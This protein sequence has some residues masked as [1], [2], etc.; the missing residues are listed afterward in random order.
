[1]LGG[2]A[3]C[4]CNANMSGFRFLSGNVM[5]IIS[6]I[7]SIDS[8]AYSSWTA[9]RGQSV[10]LTYSF[11]TRLPSDATSDDTNGFKPMTTAQQQGVR[12]ALDSWAAVANISFTEIATGGNIQLGTNDQGDQSSGYAYLP[13]GGDPVSLL[14]NNTDSYNFSFLPGEYGIS[15]LIHELGH[16]LGLKH[17]GNYNSTGGD[18]VG[19]FLPTATDNLDYTQMSYHDGAG[20]KLNGNYGVTPMLYDIQTM[21]YLYG[22]N[23]SYHSGADTY[24]FAGDA[25]L[26]CIWDAGGTDTLD[27]SAC[28]AATIINLNAGGFSETAPGYN[29]IS[30]AYNVTIERAVAGNGGATI[31]GN[32]AGNVIAG[33]SGADVIFEGAGSDQIAGGG[34][35]DTVVFSKTYADYLIS[36]TVGALTVTGD[37]S[38][39]LSGIEVLQF[40]DASVNLSSYSTIRNGISGNDQLTPGAGNELILGGAGLDQLNFGGNV[41]NYKIAASGTAVTVASLSGNGGIDLLNGV[42]RL[43]FLDADIALDINGAAGQLYRLYGAVFGRSPDSG[44][45]GYWL[46]AMDHGGTILSIASE[47]ISSAEF[48]IRYG[49]NASNETFVT[50]L[51]RNVLHREPDNSGYPWWVEQLDHG[52]SRAGVL[53]GFSE[54]L[55]NIH[56]VNPVIAV[57]I[58]YTPV[59]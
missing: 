6:G 28:N 34:G 20:Y 12:T 32:A 25:A 56:A 41:A 36:G 46:N 2:I 59:I 50:A 19:P 40:S 7:N 52:G 29:N 24:S 37:G 47:F 43:H 15:V 13:N 10:S 48:I 14:T 1:M 18:I 53:T 31:Y 27:F 23:M 55:E 11:L 17:P 5:T 49:A 35:S 3:F 58:P 45:L 9:V 39:S 26:Q 54:S 21:Q 30:I 57:G 4:E 33:G 22:A 8:L 51:Y 16:T 42:E 44:G 38:D